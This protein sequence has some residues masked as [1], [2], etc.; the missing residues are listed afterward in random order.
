MQTDTKYLE[1]PLKYAFIATLVFVV[2]A[3]LL[4]YIFQSL[5]LSA[6]DLGSTRSS[7]PEIKDMGHLSFDRAIRQF[8]FYFLIFLSLTCYVRSPAKSSS[9]GPVILFA[10]IPLMA[11]I[12]PFL[13]STGE[14]KSS[15]HWTLLAI[16]IALMLLGSK[17]MNESKS[18]RSFFFGLII[19]IV[20]SSLFSD[21]STWG[22]ELNKMAIKIYGE[23]LAD[24]KTWSSFFY[25]APAAIIS[26]AVD[27]YM[28][29]KIPS[30]FL[31]ELNQAEA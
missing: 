21:A 13:F 19:V 17:S 9:W 10:I 30:N 5:A 20:A 14:F 25:F 3:F 16:L 7:W 27:I 24:G 4:G 18:Q 23:N 6:F 1:L 8:I 2:S 15:P 28:I 22:N 31:K 12:I 29:Y 26:M 11:S